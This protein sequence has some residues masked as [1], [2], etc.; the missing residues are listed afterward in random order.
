MLCKVISGGQTGA[1]EA[2]IAAG[3]FCGLETGGHI[4]KGCLT[5]IGPR[6]EL[7]EIYGLTEH[8]SNKYPPRTIANVRNSDGTIRFAADFTTA[9]E[10]LTLRA[11]KE[12]NKPWIDVDIRDPIPTSEVVNWIKQNN[13]I[14][15]FR[16]VQIFYGF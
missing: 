11:I 5:E 1:D 12:A 7:L 6:P 10:K 4:P 8:Y 15:I 13:I 16:I 3:K 2:G 14:C 9:G